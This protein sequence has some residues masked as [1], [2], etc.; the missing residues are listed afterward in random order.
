MKIK[1]A[2]EIIKELWQIKDGIASEHGY[3]MTAFVAYLKARKH[4]EDH[5]VVDLRTMKK[6]A[7]Q[8][9][10]PDHQQLGDF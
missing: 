10:A 1:M 9:T 8:G 2:D 7:E 4:L 5:Q 6:N 3:D